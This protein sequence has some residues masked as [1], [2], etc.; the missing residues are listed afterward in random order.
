[1]LTCN[2]SRR[3]GG[4]FCPAAPR[5]CL[6][7]LFISVLML[8]LAHPLLADPGPMTI[9]FTAPG[10]PGNGIS[11]FQEALPVG[12]GKLAAMVYGGVANEQ[13]QFNEDTIWTGQPH[14]YE[15]TNATPA[16]LATIRNNC[17]NHVDILTEATTYLMSL[18]IREASYQDAG[19]LVL[20]FPQSGILNYLRSLDLT[21]ATVNVHY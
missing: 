5:F 21:S 10:T 18:P 3:A 19:S 14:Y 13:I 12:N 11:W 15:N 2:L 16:H 1:M 17:F 6:A 9:W 4:P 8:I 20:S 7:R